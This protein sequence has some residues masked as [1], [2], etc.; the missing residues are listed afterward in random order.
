VVAAAVASALEFDAGPCD[1]CIE[2]FVQF[3]DR[4]TCP[5]VDERVAIECGDRA[6]LTL[7]FDHRH[8]RASSSA[9]INPALQH[10]DHH[11]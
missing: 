5:V 9:G 4:T 7:L 2:T 3:H 6:D 11:R 10:H 1:F 8:R